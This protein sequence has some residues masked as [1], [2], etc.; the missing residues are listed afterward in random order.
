MRI[1]RASRKRQ[2]G[3]C[4]LKAKKKAAPGGGKKPSNKTDRAIRVQYGILGTVGAK[5][6]GVFSYEKV[7]EANG[8]TV[9]CEVRVFPMIVDILVAGGRGAWP[10][11]VSPLWSDRIR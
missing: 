4:E 5:S 8:G 7:L 10:S 9:P 11:A 6:I 3:T 1:A 2:Y